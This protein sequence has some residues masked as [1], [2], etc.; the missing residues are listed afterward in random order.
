MGPSPRWVIPI[1]EE[2]Y[3]C[4]LWKLLIDKNM[5]KM[6]LVE[7]ENIGIS[8]STLAKMSKGETVSMSILE[9]ICLEL[10]C[11]FGDIISIDKSK[12]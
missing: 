1:R 5:K 6:D 3:G 12:V 10:D 11:D 4:I 9:K 8:S 2:L 7:N